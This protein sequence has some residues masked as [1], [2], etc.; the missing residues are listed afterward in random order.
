[1]NTDAETEIERLTDPVR[2]AF[3]DGNAIPRLVLTK[4]LRAAMEWAYRDAA[5]VVVMEIQEHSV[6][7]AAKLDKLIKSRLL[8]PQHPEIDQSG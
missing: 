4:A 8:P 7:L 1:M 2:R 5:N 6:I 3:I